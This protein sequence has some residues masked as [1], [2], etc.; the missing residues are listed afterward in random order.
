M[1]REHNLMVRLSESEKAAFEAA[2]RLAGI[3]V[4]AWAR[5]KLRYMAV[6][7]LREADQAIPFLNEITQN[8]K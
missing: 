3:T 8:E 6:R 2:A 5:Q 4:S 1:K 7:E